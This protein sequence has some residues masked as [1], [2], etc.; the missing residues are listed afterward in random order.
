[1]PPASSRPTICRSWVVISGENDTQHR[2]GENADQDRLVALLLG[3][4]RGGEADDD[5]VVAGK[6]QV[7]ADHHQEGDDLGS[8]KV[9]SSNM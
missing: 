9:E 4:P 5:G 8:E 2:G 6:H 3:Q 7:D 1:M